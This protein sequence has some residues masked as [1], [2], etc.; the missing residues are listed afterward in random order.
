M[1]SDMNHPISR[2]KESLVTMVAGVL[3]LSHVCLHMAPQVFLAG[4]VLV[5]LRAWE[6][7]LPCMGSA[8]T[9]QV[10]GPG[11][12]FVTGEAG[13]WLVS[14]VCPLVTLHGPRHRESLVTLETAIRFLSGVRSDV[15]T[16][17]A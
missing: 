3:F 1:Y 10:T 13:K 6:G 14:C 7:F 16:Q 17:A 11:E 5:T 2:P 4:K 8:V 9:N 15:F 12:G